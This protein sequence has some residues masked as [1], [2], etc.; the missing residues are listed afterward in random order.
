MGDLGVDT[1]NSLR[2]ASDSARLSALEATRVGEEERG[3]ARGCGGG[4]N[5]VLQVVGIGAV[6]GGFEGGSDI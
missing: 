1:P 3:G 4:G 5:V 6:R 2:D